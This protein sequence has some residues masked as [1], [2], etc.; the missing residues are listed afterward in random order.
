LLTGIASQVT[1]IGQ[2]VSKIQ[3][4]TLSKNFLALRCGYLLEDIAYILTAELGHIIHWLQ[5][6]INAE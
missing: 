6:P 1:N 3:L 5:T 4:H 2:P